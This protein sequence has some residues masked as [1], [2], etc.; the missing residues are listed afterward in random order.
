LAQL[1]KPP[2]SHSTTR[3][4]EGMLHWRNRLSFYSQQ[5]PRPQRRRLMLL[6]ILKCKT[7]VH[8][9]S[10]NKAK[11]QATDWHKIVTADPG[12]EP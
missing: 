12:L 5:K 8:Q 10:I 2:T 1:E 3:P 6:V 7:L 11:R 4:P 9:D